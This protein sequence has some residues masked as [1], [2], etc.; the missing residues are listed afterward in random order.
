MISSKKIIFIGA[1]GMLG[2]PVA[3]ELIKAGYD[4]SLL[5]RDPARMQKLFPGTPIVQG[6]IFDRASLKKAFTGQDI[7]YLNISVAP[8]S[9]QAH[10]QP[11]R[12][13]M[14]NVIAIARECGAQRI[15]YLSS[16]VKSYQ[17]MNGFNW[18]SFDIKQKAVEAIR[19]SGIPFSIFYASIFMETLDKLMLRGNK[20][21]MAK[22]SVAKMWFISA[23]D[24]GK[25]VAKALHIAGSSNQE[26][27]I[28]GETGYTLDEAAFIFKKHFN[29]AIKIRYAPLGLLRF[30][31][32]FNQE[33]NYGARICE[34][35]NKYP[36]R[37]ESEKTWKDLGMPGITLEEYSKNL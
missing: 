26:Y 9:K 21:M 30:L 13:G 27:A 25:Q 20:L 33:I 4:I 37:F 32:L 29:K 36:E 5:A 7:I 16:L 31:G 17:G 28:Q 6:D 2:Q 34:A 22:G 23:A 3:I 35:L 19:S 8:S 15:A 12:E 11:E 18:W 1:T 24:Y 10:L 14:T